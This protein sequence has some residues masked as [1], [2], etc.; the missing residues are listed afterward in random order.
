MTNEANNS[1]SNRL[2]RVIRPW[3][4]LLLAPLILVLTVYAKN[5]HSILRTVF[6]GITAAQALN[7]C[8]YMVGGFTFTLA[9]SKA[10]WLLGALIF[11]VAMVIEIANLPIW[12]PEMILGLENITTLLKIGVSYVH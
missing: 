1:L 10:L 8:T 12:D 5:P 2:F 3:S 9:K 6:F 4:A 11:L 7:M